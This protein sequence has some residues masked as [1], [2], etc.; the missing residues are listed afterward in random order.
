[1]KTTIFARVIAKP[2]SFPSDIEML[3]YCLDEHEA[4]TGKTFFGV[5]F[6]WDEV[7]RRFWI[8]AD[9][10]K[11]CEEFFRGGESAFLGNKEVIIEVEG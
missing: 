8:D 3:Y 2:I 5:H 10:A 11:E 4:L 1:M 9:Y 6:S 7:Q